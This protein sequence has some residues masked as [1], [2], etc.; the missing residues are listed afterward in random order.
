MSLA[1]FGRNII[2]KLAHQGLN[3]RA[4]FLKNIAVIGWVLSSLAQTCAVVF[5]D[6]IPTKEK[7]FLVPQEIF[8]GITNATLFWFIT[9]KSTDFG[10]SLILKK[11]I[12]PANLTNALK[13]YVPKGKTIAQLKNNFL[14]HFNASKEIA[15]L[16]K[17][18]QQSVEGMGIL[19]GLVGAIVANNIITPFVRNKL[20]GM[21]QQK[22]T[23]KANEKTYLNPNFGNIDYSRYNYTKPNLETSPYYKNFKTSPTLKI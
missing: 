7:R 1:N 15:H 22:E 13:N 8:D 21:Y 5:N 11:K 4:N 16:A 10:K 17:E 6:K 3:D 9:S 2:T 20:A 23:I 12:I 14:K 19:T 18:A